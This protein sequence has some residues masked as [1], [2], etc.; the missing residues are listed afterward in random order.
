MSRRKREQSRNIESLSLSG[1]FQ[2]TTYG[3]HFV[4]DSVRMKLISKSFRRL[5]GIAI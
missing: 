4:P 3:I 5:W 2:S 1:I